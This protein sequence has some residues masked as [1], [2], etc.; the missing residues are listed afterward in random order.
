M[1]DNIRQTLF[2]NDNVQVGRDYIQYVVTE[3]PIR[4]NEADLRSLISIFSENM[5][6]INIVKGSSNQDFG[7]PGIERKNEINELSDR[8]FKQIKR[9]SLNYFNKIDRFLENPINTELREKYDEI[10][11]E[12]NNLV[13]CHRHQFRF[14]DEVFSRLYTYVVDRNRDNIPFDVNLVWVFLHYMYCTCDL[15]EKDD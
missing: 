1:S 8:Y 11:N 7:Y 2:G 13:F 9:N 4:F 15:G 12:M 10:A 6:V 14:Y 5:G 3:T